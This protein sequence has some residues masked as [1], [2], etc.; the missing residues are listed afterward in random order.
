MKLIYCS[1]CKDVVQLRPDRRSCFCGKSEGFYRAPGGVDVEIKGPCL[2]IGV[3]NYEMRDAMKRYVDGKDRAAFTAF[4]FIP[5]MGQGKFNALPSDLGEE[6]N[7]E[8]TFI[9]RVVRG[10]LL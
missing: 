6:D 9:R 4:F 1:V 10:N 3:D 7:P 2:V 8:L 5:Q